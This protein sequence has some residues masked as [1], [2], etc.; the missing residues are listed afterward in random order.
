M[1]LDNNDTVHIA[2]LTTDISAAT[3]KTFTPVTANPD[4]IA[5]PNFPKG[6]YL[7]GL[8]TV[9]STAADI[10]SMTAYFEYTT[11]G[12][13][14]WHRGGACEFVA[15]ATDK[16]PLQKVQGAIGLL[17]IS[18]EAEA[19]GQIRWRVVLEWDSSTSTSDPSFEFFLAGDQGIEA[20]KNA[21]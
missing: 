21:Q 6:L 5:W 9:A 1:V 14:T 20:V 3:S 10:V 4:R 19:A 12:G 8:V 13:T 2:A 15:N 7:V 18:P 11:D 16:V 17:D